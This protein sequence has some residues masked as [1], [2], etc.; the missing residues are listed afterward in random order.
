VSRL[1]SG[2]WS[3]ADGLQVW[4]HL[5]ASPLFQAELWLGLGIPLVI[6]LLP[7]TRRSPG[8][9]LIAAC[10]AVVA[11][12]VARYHFIVGGQMVASFKGSWAH[13]LLQYSP[14][15][16]EWAVLATAVFLA[17]VV[18]AAGEQ[19]LSLGSPAP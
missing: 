4:N 7:A 12:F 11:L 8:M 2:L 1:V 19:R 14:S 16:T 5:W 15:L 10:V 18:N 17:N 9:Q 6:M 13:G 3:N